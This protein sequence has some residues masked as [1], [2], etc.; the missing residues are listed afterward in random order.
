MIPIV[1]VHEDY[2]NFLKSS[3]EITGKNNKIYLIG[4]E[5]VKQLDSHPSVTYIDIKKYSKLESLKQFQNEFVHEGDKDRRTYMFWFLRLLIMHEFA[6][7]YGFESFFSSDSDNVILNDINKFTFMQKN[8]L[9]IANEWEPFNYSASIHAGLL[10]LEF[11]KIYEQLLFEFY[12]NNIENSFFSKKI[13][14]HKSN[15]GSFCDMTIYYHMYKEGLIEIDNLMEPRHFQNLNYVFT[16][17]YASPEGLESKNQYRTRFNRLL[18]KKD[19]IN[20]SNYILNRNNNKKEYIMN[21][22]FQGKQ[23]KFLNQKMVRW[24]NL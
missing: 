16:S 10:N 6:K 12:L 9:L 2:N 18:I 15:P 5:S 4:N 3:I 19:N 23:K 13:E 14:F 24:L 21:I 7:D 1:I 20:N 17:S 11:C 22:H 8:A